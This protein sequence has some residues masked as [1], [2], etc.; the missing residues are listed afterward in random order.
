MPAFLVALMVVVLLVIGL[1]A[2]L[3]LTKV[4]RREGDAVDA[5][6]SH[7]RPDT[8]PTPPTEER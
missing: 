5:P 8:A 2:V 4:L 7:S 6:Q 1:A 3:L